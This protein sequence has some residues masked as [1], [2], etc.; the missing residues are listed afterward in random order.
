MLSILTWTEIINY[1]ANLL[2]NGI[3]SLMLYNLSNLFS[4][5]KFIIHMTANAFD[6]QFT[7]L[8]LRSCLQGVT[9]V[10]TAYELGTC[11]VSIAI[12]ILV[13]LNWHRWTLVLQIQKSD[14]LFI[15]NVYYWTTCVGYGL[16]FI[17]HWVRGYV[18]T[19]RCL[20]SMSARW[21]WPY[22]Y[23]VYLSKNTLLQIQPIVKMIIFVNSFP[24]KFG[25]YNYKRIFKIC[26]QYWC[27][28][29]IEGNGHLFL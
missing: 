13:S 8:Y 29:D 24:L 1:R 3:S 2:Y 15:I 21:W 17:Y 19:E 9:I 18:S 5:S 16:L 25:V 23:N 26:A 10:S 22:P 27:I 12:F 7:T 11:I 6:I 28:T 14:C 4:L 20:R